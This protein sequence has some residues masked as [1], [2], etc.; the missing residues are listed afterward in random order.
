MT[1]VSQPATGVADVGDLGGLLR[2][3]RI[4]DGL[5]LRQLQAQLRN[6]LSASALSRI[7]NGATPDPKNVPAIAAWLN[8]PI[9]QI[10]WPGQAT[11]TSGGDSTPD[12]VEVH[13]RADK[14]L[15]PIAADVLAMTFRRLYDDIV[16]GKIPL[17]GG[18]R[19]E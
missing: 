8:I 6:A 11:A 15:S 5:T 14:K 16:D 9:S 18:E 13:L 12:V 17:A 10:A 7:E 2:K 4:A 3:R 1:S 19:T